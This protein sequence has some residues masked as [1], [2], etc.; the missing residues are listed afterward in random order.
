M[1]LDLL[2]L[3][4]PSVSLL[5]AVTAMHV[6]GPVDGSPFPLH[7]LAASRSPVALDTALYTLLNLHPADLPLWREAVRRR[8]PGAAPGDLAFPLEP[9][10][11]F[12]AQGFVMPAALQ[13]AGFHPYRV[14]RRLVINTWSAV[15]DKN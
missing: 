1:F 15:F 3:L 2:D 6:T 13:P 9:L 11:S 10:E 8:L 12:D 4:P 14:A 7:L 5:D